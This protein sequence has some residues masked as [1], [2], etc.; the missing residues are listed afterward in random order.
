MKILTKILNVVVVLFVIIGLYST[1]NYFWGRKHVPKND[2][3]Q[4]IDSLTNEVYEKNVQ[5]LQ[6]ND[7]LDIV[8]ELR[9]NEEKRWQKEKES[10]L[11]KVQENHEAE[12]VSN[13]PL[14]K[15][16]EYILEYYNTDSTEAKIVQNGDSIVVM[17]TPKLIH[18]IGMTVAEN[19]DNLTKL[20]AY[21]SY[22]NISDSLIETQAEEINLLTTKSIILESINKD[23]EGMNAENKDLIT[24]KNK[25]IRKYKLISIGTGVGAVVLIVLIAL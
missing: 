5:L 15:M 25:E 3:Q 8:S 2:Y 16:L 6:V 13:L 19:R 23:L 10:L 12:L 20:T 7:V 17:V 18:S 22:V 24:A 14:D 4:T 9:I 1:V 11:K 21:K